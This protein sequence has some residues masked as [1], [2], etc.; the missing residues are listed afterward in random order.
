MFQEG[1]RQQSGRGYLWSI[2][3][4]SL[5]FAFLTF[6][7]YSLQRNRAEARSRS[8]QIEQS[9]PMIAD[10]SLESAPVR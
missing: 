9:R 1:K 6:S 7:E 8:F 10:V 3:G 2:A 4:L 5:I